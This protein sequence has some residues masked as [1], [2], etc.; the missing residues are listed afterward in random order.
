MVWL[1][2]SDSAEYFRKESLGS[3]SSLYFSF[4]LEITLRKILFID[5]LETHLNINKYEDG[6]YRLS[7]HSCDRINLCSVKPFTAFIE[8]ATA[9]HSMQKVLES[10]FLYL[11][12]PC[13]RRSNWDLQ[14]RKKV[15]WLLQRPISA[16]FTSRVNDFLRDYLL[17]IILLNWIDIK[18]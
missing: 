17:V 1:E 16:H 2:D 9:D 13:I 15:L 7:Y 10:S 3:F 11:T 18:I 4:I 12:C 6:T 8:W 14:I 5:M